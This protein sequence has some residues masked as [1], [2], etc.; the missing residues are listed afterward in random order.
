MKQLENSKDILPSKK[1]T[2]KKNS[3]A[4][5]DDKPKTIPTG[6]FPDDELEVDDTVIFQ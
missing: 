1:S 4:Y 3:K 5:I 6:K 2:K